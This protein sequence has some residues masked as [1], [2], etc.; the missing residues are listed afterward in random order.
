[1]KSNRMA[2]AM[3]AA[4][5]ALCLP[6]RSGAY[7]L[8]ESDGGAPV[9]WHEGDRSVRIDE[10][11]RHLGPAGQSRE[12]VLDALSAWSSVEDSPFAFDCET[13]FRSGLGMGER[14]DGVTDVSLVEQGWELDPDFLAITLVTYDAT[15]GVIWDADVVLNAD[16]H[17]FGVGEL[18]AGQF[19]ATSVL[20]HE[21]G[22][23]VGLGHSEVQEAT[24]YATSLPG[25]TS[26]RSLEADDEQGLLALYAGQSMDGGAGCSAIRAG[27]GAD[28]NL[29]WIALGT[30]AWLLRRRTG[31]ARRRRQATVKTSRSDAANVS[32]RR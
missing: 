18:G 11:L 13:K 8:R 32:G 26:R 20:T 12:A 24:M 22:H 3:V 31:G 30:G 25:Q 4:G 5:A 29:G 27:L 21:V 7:T 6:G 2:L 23:L 16:D 10:G 14:L 28:V 9:R 15:T 19:D 17:E 1:M